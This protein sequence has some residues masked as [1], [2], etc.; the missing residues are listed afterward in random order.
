MNCGVLRRSLFIVTASALHQTSDTTDSEPANWGVEWVADQCGAWSISAVSRNA[1]GIGSAG[2]EWMI[3]SGPDGAQI[4]SGRQPVKISQEIQSL[5]DGIY[6]PAVAKVWTKNDQVNKRCYFG[7]PVASAQMQIL[8]L[9]YRNL[10]G[11]SIAS[12]PPV[13]ISFT[14]KMIASD[15]TRK[16]TRWNLNAQC[17][18]LMYRPG[19]AAPVV[20]LGAGIAGANIYTLNSAKFSDDD[21]GQIF[22]YYTT[23]FFVSHEQEAALQ[24]GSHRKKYQYVSA[25]I[26]GV[27]TYTIT[28]LAAALSNA[29]PATPPI[30][31]S[32]DPQFDFESGINVETTRCAFKIAP[33]PLTGQTDAAFSLQKLVVNMQKS[34]WQPVRG[35]NSG[36]F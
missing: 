31:L 25:F 26:S 3:W 5:W 35:S 13:H 21:F 14:G 1:Q 19:Q 22:S 34:N 9:D 20:C 23:Y 16:W 30:V 8:A 29:M 36:Q 6:Q 12:S 11:E 15:L 7:I 27:G 28:P 10:D 18:E 17:G 4:F 32:S 33:A 2:K 24:V